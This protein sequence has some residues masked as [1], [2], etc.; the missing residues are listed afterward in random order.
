MDLDCRCALEDIRAGSCVVQGD[1]GIEDMGDGYQGSDWHVNTGH[2]GDLMSAHYRIKKS[3]RTFIVYP[4]PSVQSSSSLALP[5]PGSPH[6]L[7]SSSTS[8]Q[9]R[10]ATSTSASTSRST[11]STKSTTRSGRP[12]PSTRIGSVCQSRLYPLHLISF[13]FQQL[14]DDLEPLIAEGGLILD[15]HTCEAFPERWADLVVVLRCDHTR[16]WERLEK[17]FVPSDISLITRKLTRFI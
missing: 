4:W 16:L 14:L 1:I 13:F 11:V 9:C 5:A 15:W 17:R 7:S 3:I 10:C 8:P 6:M 2:H 12:T